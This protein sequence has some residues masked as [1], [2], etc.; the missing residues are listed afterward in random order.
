MKSPTL[1]RKKL[2]VNSTTFPRVLNPFESHTTLGVVY[3]A[4]R[5]DNDILAQ[6]WRRRSRT[7][8]APDCNAAAPDKANQRGL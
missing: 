1:V 7:E 2:L 8:T 4:T 3:F 6:H 5:H